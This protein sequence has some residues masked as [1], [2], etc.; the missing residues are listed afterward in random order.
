MNPRKILPT[1]VELL[2]LLAYALFS[3]FRFALIAPFTRSTSL[4]P[5]PRKPK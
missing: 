5:K 2:S 3:V 1:L 4:K